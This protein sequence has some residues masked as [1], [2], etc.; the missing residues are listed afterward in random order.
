MNITVMMTQPVR[1]LVYILRACLSL[2]AR[3]D[4]QKTSAKYS[5]NYV[6]YDTEP[7]LYADQFRFCLK[8]C[9]NAQNPNRAVSVGPTFTM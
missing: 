8:G 7:R 9:L 3:L 6:M 2:V 4:V 1:S 5:G